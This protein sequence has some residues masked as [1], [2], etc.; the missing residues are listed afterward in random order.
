MS[1]TQV[2]QIVPLLVVELFILANYPQVTRDDMAPHR[3][4]DGDVTGPPERP[5]RQRIEGVWLA[6]LV[7]NTGGIILLALRSVGDRREG[8]ND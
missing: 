4:E 5:W 8:R 2:R 6:A 7:A 1:V 3:L